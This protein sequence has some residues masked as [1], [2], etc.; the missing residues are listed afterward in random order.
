M[1]KLGFLREKSYE[2]NQKITLSECGE[3][4]F[5]LRIIPTRLICST[6]ITPTIE[7]QDT[8]AMLLRGELSEASCTPCSLHAI[9]L[10]TSLIDYQNTNRVEIAQIFVL[11]TSGKGLG[12]SAPRTK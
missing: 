4:F 1:M 9:D 2:T 10:R 12:K 7:D 8:Y 6:R 11:D 5:L 3:I